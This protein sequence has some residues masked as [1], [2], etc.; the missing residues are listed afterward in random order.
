MDIAVPTLEDIAA[1]LALAPPDLPWKLEGPCRH[2]IR[3]ILI[4]TR[5]TRSW[6]RADLEARRLVARGRLKNGVRMPAGWD[7]DTDL[8]SWV[9]TIE[10]AICG[11][12][13]LQKVLA[14]LAAVRGPT[15]SAPM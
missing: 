3:A 13:V 1:I 11:K 12:T 14:G 10:C 7:A 8:S 5:W 4:L 2:R 6:H 15:T 9:G